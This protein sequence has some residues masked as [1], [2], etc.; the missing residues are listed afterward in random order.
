MTPEEKL[1]Y[2]MQGRW[3]VSAPE[4]HLNP[5]SNIGGGSGDSLYG[6]AGYRQL[7]SRQAEGL[8]HNKLDEIET[9]PMTMA[10]PLMDFPTGGGGGIMDP[11]S[12]KVMETLEQFRALADAQE[13]GAF[14]LPNTMNAVKA[15]NSMVLDAR[16]SYPDKLGDPTAGVTPTASQLSRLNDVLEGSGFGVSST[17]RGAVIFP[18]DSSM[19]SKD[20]SKF[21]KK[22]KDKFSEIFPSEPMMA[23]TTTGYVPGVG[24][25]GESGPLSTVPYSG[26]A[27]SDMLSAFS[28]IPQH[29][30]QNIGESEAVRQA[31]REK[32]LRDS[33]LGG[34]R[35]DI[36]ETRRFM[37]EADWP[38]AVEMIRQGMAPAAAIA[39]LGYNAASMASEK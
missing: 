38:K 9:N 11:K 16:S 30:V 14:N 17:N 15:K 22:N 27:T 32:A 19:S 37:S 4:Q 2:G 28:E 20:A 10:R 8:Y 18:F 33:K 1:A 31:I 13:A 34:A 21:L 25:R 3:D 24:K 26:E 29:V 6:A 35:G 36:Q 5:Y 12:S 23:K 7:P 39:A